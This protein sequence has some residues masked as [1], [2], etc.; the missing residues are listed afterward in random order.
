MRIGKLGLVN[1]RLFS[2]IEF[3]FS[4]GMNLIVGPSGS[5]K[6]TIIEAI[7]FAIYGEPL[8]GANLVDLLGP[9][10]DTCQI[11][12]SLSSPLETQI[13]RE[14]KRVEKNIFQRIIFNG[15]DVKISDLSKMEKIFPDKKLFFEAISVDQL[16]FNHLLEM[17]TQ[18]FQDIFSSVL[19]SWDMKCV[20][21]NSRSLQ[22]Y[23]KSK[24]EMLDE[25]LT[26][27]KELSLKQQNLT[28]RL[29]DYIDNKT[30][31]LRKYEDITQKVKVL[32]KE[33][34]KN[35]D[36][37]R[38]MERFIET[39]EKQERSVKRL[40][41]QTEQNNEVL[42]AEGL[43]F[44]DNESFAKYLD[45]YFSFTND[46][47]RKSENLL[48]F[49]NHILKMMD[50][51]KIKT[52]ELNKELSTVLKEKAN[53]EMNLQDAS[54]KTIAYENSSQ[55]V[56]EF[57][58]KC[59]QYVSEL[60]EIAETQKIRQKLEDLIH[61]LWEENFSEFMSKLTNR[62]NQK[63]KELDVQMQLAADNGE[64]KLLINNRLVGFE[65]LSG[66]ERTILNLMI[67]TA[68]VKELNASDIIILDDP[69]A[70]L[71]RDKASKIFSFLNSLKRT[72]VK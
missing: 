15:K 16:R 47:C 23:L 18:E 57:S 66:G 69:I 67:K 64:L 70:F 38:R 48:Q 52:N 30:F 55:L 43:Y 25:H 26:E 65:V 33:I 11:T 5:G 28:N 37:N 8:R 61:V 22:F 20:L 59:D 42:K 27:T 19:F 9:R 31:L 40:L 29:R 34:S 39:I 50:V 53:L 32:E 1:F 4:Q 71:D 56:K 45:D 24:E 3:S 35:I 21:D 46:L 44:A 7:G 17:K 2:D 6:T 14:I 60:K 68:L 12:L 41:R 49:Q 62:I 51:S 58:R 36:E 10:G 54:S 63:L 13:V 72:S